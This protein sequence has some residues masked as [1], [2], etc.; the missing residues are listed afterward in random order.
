MPRSNGQVERFNRT[1]LDSLKTV[2]ANTS[3]DNW[4]QYVKALQQGLNSTIHKSTKAV[5]SEV[6]LGYRLRT[7]SDSLA[8][9][10]DDGPVVDVTKLRKEVDTNIKS[11]ALSQKRAF[12]K[13]RTKAHEYGEGD[14]VMT[15]IQSQS[16]DGRSK[17]L[18]PVFKGPFKIKKVLGNDRYEVEDILF[19]ERSGKRYTGVAAAE[20]LKRWIRIDDWEIN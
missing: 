19:S 14:L 3:D 1:I 16:N 9:Q 6:F 12:D 15:K 5:P 18:L 10:L 4:D 11:N 7:D 17:K 8:P 20:N 13:G 2:G